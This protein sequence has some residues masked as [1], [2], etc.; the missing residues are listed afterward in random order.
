MNRTVYVF[1][2]LATMTSPTWAQASDGAAPPRRGDCS[3]PEMRQLDFWIG[4]WNVSMTGHKDVIASSKIE[5]LLDGCGISERYDSPAAPG[6]PY[7][8]VSYSGYDRNDALWHQMYLDVNGNVTWYT[9]RLT[10]HEMVFTAPGRAGALQRMS[11]V[12]EDDGTVRQVGETSVD[13]GATWRLAYDYTY[14]RR[15]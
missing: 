3:A 15:N 7:S 11:Y 2:I 9:G 12:P 14:R 6:G 8:G 1:L 4:D 5:K 13:G 10:G